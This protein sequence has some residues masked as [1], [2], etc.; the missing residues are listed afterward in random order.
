MPTKVLFSPKFFLKS[1][2]A[3]FGHQKHFHADSVA[4]THFYYQK[5]TDSNLVQ[6]EDGNLFFSKPLRYVSVLI[7]GI[8]YLIVPFQASFAQFDATD[9]PFIDEINHPYAV[10][11]GEADI[12]RYIGGGLAHVNPALRGKSEFVRIG[13]NFT[14]RFLIVPDFKTQP[15]REFAPEI[16]YVTPH[17]GVEYEGWD[18]S[19]QLRYYIM[20]EQVNLEGRRFQSAEN[21]QEITVSRAFSPRFRAGTSLNFFQSDRGFDPAG[22]VSGISMHFGAIFADELHLPGFSL[23]P[24][25]GWSLTNFGRARTY[26]LGAGNSPLPTTMRLGGSLRFEFDKE[27]RNF[28]AVSATLH[29]AFS[30]MII[31]YNTRDLTPY[32][33]FE[34]L[35]RS[36]NNYLVRD[37]DEFI[38]ITVMDQIRRHLGLEIE[39]MEVFQLRFGYRHRPDQLESHQRYTI[40]AGINLTY[41]RLD[42]SHIL[43]DYNGRYGQTLWMLTVAAP[44]DWVIT[45]FGEE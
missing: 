3:K 14:P 34:A 42:M 5:I 16:F 13:S 27:Y 31:G 28:R 7:F 40:G 15:N 4:E 21:I 33:S 11:L 23:Y 45:S 12:T 32:D 39:L 10:A 17:I 43:G 35:L 9:F 2:S 18:A 36:W 19:F 20:G 8:F 41:I 38:E 24:S 37:G 44:L 29:T 1:S 22:T 6:N 26:A 25:L 30:R